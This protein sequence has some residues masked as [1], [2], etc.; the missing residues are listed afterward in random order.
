ML[1]IGLP[2]PDLGREERAWLRRPEVSGVILFA[3]NIR[4][5]RQLRRLNEAIRETAGRP[6]LTAV[7]QEGGPVQ[8]LR[9]EGFTDLPALAAIGMLHRHDP[10]LARRAARLHAR[11]MVA[12]VRAAGFD[13]SLAPVA[14]LACGNRAIGPRAFSPDPV[15]CAEL[16][17][18]YVAAMTEAGMAATLKHFPGHGSVAE[19]THFEW[20]CDPRPPAAWEA[21]DWRPFR[22]G[23]AAGARAVMMA[24]VVCPA[25]GE[26]PA[27]AE[28]GLVGLLRAELGFRGVVMSDDLAMRGTER[29]G[30][31][32]SRILAH[33]AAGCELLLI[34][35]PAD[36]PEALAVASAYPPLPPE[37]L[38]LLLGQP[39]P[40]DPDP[41][42]MAA[43]RAMLA[44]LCA[45]ES[46]PR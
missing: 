44:R 40:A 1:L 27:G 15:V 45:G 30:D 28:P 10:E 31:L 19:D 39:A 26:R 3:R 25:W 2:G 14:D 41:D 33:R 4:D 7:D 9:G 38:R 18:C 11:V 36:V 12:E 29:L 17:A 24:H 21:A 20:A 16:V 34:C 6:L 5:P 8:R 13:L 35:Q 37:R 46:L 42:E 22:A 43:A 23:I 32:R